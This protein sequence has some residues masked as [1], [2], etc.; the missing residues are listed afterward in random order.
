MSSDLLTAATPEQESNPSDLPAP[1]QQLDALLADVSALSKLALDIVQRS[2]NLDDKVVSRLAVDL[3]RHSVA[4]NNQIPQV[5]HSHVDVAIAEIRRTLSFTV[6][7]PI[8][9]EILPAAR[10]F[11][12]G[13][14]PTPAELDTLFPLG[15]GDNKAYHVV[16]VGQAPGLYDTVEE[17]NEQVHGVPAQNRRRVV[18]RLSALAYYQQMFD[19]QRVM[20]LTQDLP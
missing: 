15:Q 10:V 3:T 19:A 5:V 8:S 4:I 2:I 6:S 9:V 14:A 7:F 17:A 16:C 13:T 20:A 1:A 18:G 12:Q 11:Y